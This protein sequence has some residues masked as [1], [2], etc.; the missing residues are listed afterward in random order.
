MQ[1]SIYI[2]PLIVTVKLKLYTTFYMG[3]DKINIS[4]KRLLLHLF[5]DSLIL[6]A[7]LKSIG[8]I[9]GCPHN[10]IPPLQ[11]NL[12]SQII[13]AFACQINQENCLLQKEKK[14]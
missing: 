9:G 2:R 5:Y 6:M 7:Q 11:R 1:G 4:L 3:P 14:K 8:S 10:R 13:W 12:V